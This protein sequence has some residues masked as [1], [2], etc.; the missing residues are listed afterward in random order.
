MQQTHPLQGNHSQHEPNGWATFHVSSNPF[1]QTQSRV[2]GFDSTMRNNSNPFS[3]NQLKN[4]DGLTTGA[5]GEWWQAVRRIETCGVRR[6]GLRRCGLRRCGLRRLRVETLRVE[7]CG[8]VLNVSPSGRDGESSS[9]RGFLRGF[10]RI[11]LQRPANDLPKRPTRERSLTASRTRH[12]SQGERSQ[13]PLMTRANKAVVHL[14]Q[15][16]RSQSNKGIDHSVSPPP[17]PTAPSISALM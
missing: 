8:L 3:V 6:C 9:Q 12:L 13:R 2:S 5:I 4:R 14:S 11:M 17:I 16:E 10:L 15:G 1:R 7:T